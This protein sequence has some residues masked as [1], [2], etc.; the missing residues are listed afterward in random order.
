MALVL[1]RI[2]GKRHIDHSLR[3]ILLQSYTISYEGL[4]THNIPDTPHHLARINHK[5]TGTEMAKH[6][7]PNRG[8]NMAFI[9]HVWPP[10]KSRKSHRPDGLAD[11]DDATP[12]LQI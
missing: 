10:P 11:L 8:T 12:Q 1:G 2:P 4:V 9:K 6:K 5:K 3:I 7:P